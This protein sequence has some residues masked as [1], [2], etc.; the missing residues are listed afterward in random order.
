MV[1]FFY[2]GKSFGQLFSPSEISLQ[3]L[4]SCSPFLIRP[5][6]A[7]AGRLV[8]TTRREGERLVIR[9]SALPSFARITTSAP[10]CFHV[11]GSSTKRSSR[12]GAPRRAEPFA[13]ISK[14]SL[15]RRDTGAQEVEVAVGQT[16]EKGHL[17]ELA[18]D[19]LG[20]EGRRHGREATRRSRGA[21][22]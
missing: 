5:Q 11:A 16:V 7:G 1:M 17:A 3:T 2:A 12:P 6:P 4:S 14:R 18:A 13:S 8:S 19:L 20:L 9:S 21:S 15:G 10:E 22:W